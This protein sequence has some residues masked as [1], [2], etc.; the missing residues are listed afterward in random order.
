MTPPWRGGGGGGGSFVIIQNL[1]CIKMFLWP[2][3]IHIKNYESTAT[4]NIL[5][6]GFVKFYGQFITFGVIASTGRH[7]LK[8]TILLGKKYVLPVNKYDNYGLKVRSGTIVA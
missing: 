2:R 1:F 8:N 3:P 6:M 4:E 5:I 7:T